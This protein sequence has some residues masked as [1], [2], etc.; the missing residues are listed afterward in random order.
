MAFLP[1]PPSYY[2]DYF[3]RLDM[4]K[5][6][7]KFVAAIRWLAEGGRDHARLLMARADEDSQFDADL[8][9]AFEWINDL[10]SGNDI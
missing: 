6:V 10:T 1:P 3:R 4:E 5:E 9:E 8:D 2:K 7:D